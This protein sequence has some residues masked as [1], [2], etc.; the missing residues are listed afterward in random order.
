MVHEVVARRVLQAVRGIEA[1][2][3]Y[4]EKSY[5]GPSGR[6][7]GTNEVL[8]NALGAPAGEV[9]YPDGGDKC[10]LVFQDNG[11]RVWLE[12]KHSWTW[13][14]YTNPAGPNPLRWKHLLSETENSAL[15]DASVK[16]PRLI[17]SREACLLGLLLIALDSNELSYPLGDIKSLAQLAGMNTLPWEGHSSER[18]SSTARGYS[19]IRIQPFLWLRSSRA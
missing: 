12:V 15:R 13:M 19:T 8:R 7:A 10:D 16:L 5:K 11:Q 14:T 4:E 3:R 18:W 2:T 1:E 17:D 6:I 9:S